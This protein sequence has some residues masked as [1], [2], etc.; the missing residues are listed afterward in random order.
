MRNW[1][2]KILGGSTKDEVLTEAV[3]RLHNTVSVQ[4]VLRLEEGKLMYGVKQLTTA[5]YAILQEQVR[6]FQKS[7]LFKVLD[8]D[9]KYNCNQLMREATNIQQLETA[10]VTEFVFDIIKT[11]LKNF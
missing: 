8:L 5:E 7:L 6:S 9:L 3:I 2:I 1:L 10:K 11:R 4:D